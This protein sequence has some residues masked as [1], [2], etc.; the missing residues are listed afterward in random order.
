MFAAARRPCAFLLIP[1][2]EPFMSRAI[3]IDATQDHVIATCAKNNLPIS[4]IEPL[5][6]GGTRVVMNTV[7]DR[8]AIARTYGSKVITGPVRRTPTRLNHA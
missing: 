6:S 4:A 5:R 1:F 8:A 2:L 3:N 7:I